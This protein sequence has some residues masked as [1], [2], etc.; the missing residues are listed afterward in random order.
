[1]T[2]DIILIVAAVALCST[3]MVLSRSWPGLSSA[4]YVAA[5]VAAVLSILIGINDAHA[6]TVAHA[7]GMENRMLILTDDRCTT[8]G[9]TGQVAL[10]L[11][12]Y[13][14]GHSD[15]PGYIV[16]DGCWKRESA[17]TVVIV[18]QPDGYAMQYGA[19]QFHWKG[20]K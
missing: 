9:R 4:I 11:S 2:L 5:F 18:W 19:E 3:G 12:F 7:N 15:A 6:G 20:A 16:A 13:K 14:Q 8:G 1:M 10:V 17:K